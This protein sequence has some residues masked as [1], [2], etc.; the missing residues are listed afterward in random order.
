[1]PDRLGCNACDTFVNAD[2]NLTQIQNTWNQNDC[3]ASVGLCSAIACLP[4]KSAVCKAGD[5]GGGLCVD[6]S[7]VATN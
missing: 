4:P 5:A 3:Q 6:Q 7:A 2:T 1:M